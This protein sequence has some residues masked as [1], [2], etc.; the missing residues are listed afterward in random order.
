VSALPQ[1]TGGGTVYSIRRALV[2]DQE[3][4]DTTLYEDGDTLERQTKKPS[5]I[6]R[7]CQETSVGYSLESLEGEPT[8]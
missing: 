8:E 7:G 4:E 5:A 2:K 3:H 1:K 6:K